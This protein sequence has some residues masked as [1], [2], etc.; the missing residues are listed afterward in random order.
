MKRNVSIIIPAYNVEE[1]IR[2][3]IE[4]IEHQTYQNYEL[5]IIDD[6]STD[7]TSEIIREASNTNHKIKLFH[8]GHQGV[9]NARNIGLDHACG[10]YITFV[11]SDDFLCDNYLEELVNWIEQEHADI[12]ICGTNDISEDGKIIKQSLQQAPEIQDAKQFAADIVLCQKYTCTVWGKIYRAELLK[13]VRFDTSI[14]IAEDFKFLYA[15]SKEVNIVY[16][17]P[18]PLYNWLLRQTSALH[19][20]RCRQTY[21]ALHTHEEI[22]KEISKS[23]MLYHAVV[24]GYVGMCVECMKQA[25]EENDKEI[26]SSCKRKVRK[27]MLHFLIYAKTAPVQKIKTVIKTII[28]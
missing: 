13:K 14:Q 1:Y 5:I 22:L 16:Y 4:S 8:G 12:A 3:C 2:K 20:A 24:E 21:R 7:R 26:K 23:G 18:K 11:D 25:R 9:S 27:K 19:T 10:D 15:V 28:W 6:G 17:D